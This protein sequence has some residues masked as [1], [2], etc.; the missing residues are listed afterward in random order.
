MPDTPDDAEP[1][2]A[3]RRSA[4][5]PIPDDTAAM[6]AQGPEATRDAPGWRIADRY[7]VVARIGSGGMADVFR[8]QDELLQRDVAVK[9]FRTPLSTP[10]TA[11]GVERQRAELLA[12]ARLNHPH[13]ITLYDGSIGDTET[14]GAPAYLVMELIEGPTLAD[15][16]EQGAMPEPEIRAIGRQVADALAYVHD[17]GMVHR[18][19]KPANI[20]LGSGGLSDMALV[21]ARL[22]DFGIVRLLGSERLTSV[23]STLGTASY[24]AP[25]QA[26]GSGVGPA[27]DVYA[28]GL[29][30]LEAFTGRR[31]FDG[32]TPLEAAVAR[33][34]RDPVIPQQLPVPWPGLLAAM[35]NRDPAARPTAAQVAQALRNPSQAT[36]QLLRPGGGAAAGTAVLPAV[37]GGPPLPPALPASARPAASPPRKSRT[38]LWVGLALAALIIALGIAIVLATSSGN[39]SP[40]PATSPSTTPTT[41][42]STPTRSTHS[43]PSTTRSNSA[44]STR[45]KP[46]SSS[47]QPSRS[48]TG[49]S[50][51]RSRSSSASKPTPSSTQPSRPGQTTSP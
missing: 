49:A 44:Q 5:E 9:V 15:R 40:G 22:S 18:D 13:L 34:V 41:K 48:S 7:R 43:Q 17:T 19:V 6:P 24:L 30:L 25:E 12:H 23:D 27:A 31:A 4:P 51:S 29:T 37:R 8:A 50:T 21:R 1:T 3:H 33:L 46:S 16:I 2:G 45:P 39:N 26:R 38:G 20:L 36:T 47:R 35:T 11:A 28:L 42:S 32:D 14:A 10:H